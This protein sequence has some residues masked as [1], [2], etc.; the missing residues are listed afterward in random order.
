[1]HSVVKVFIFIMTNVAKGR[2]NR[3][4]PLVL[5]TDKMS[6]WSSA[7][8]CYKDRMAKPRNM[9]ASIHENNIITLVY[10]VS[11]LNRIGLETSVLHPTDL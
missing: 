8:P 7:M 2:M 1:M 5:Y 4:L 10:K 3:K 11:K 9:K 6:F